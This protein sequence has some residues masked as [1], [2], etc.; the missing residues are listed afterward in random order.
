MIGVLF[1]LLVVDQLLLGAVGCLGQNA[2]HL[3]GHHAR[4]A[5]GGVVQRFIDRREAFHLQ[6]R[7][8]DLVDALEHAGQ[9]GNL[10]L[11]LDFILR[12]RGNRLLEAFH[13]RPHNRLRFF[14]VFQHLE[15]LRL[16]DLGLVELALQLRAL[17]LQLGI[18]RL[19]RH[20]DAAVELGNLL[21]QPSGF[22]PP[23]LILRL[24]VHQLARKLDISRL[25]LAI[26]LGVLGNRRVKRLDGA[27]RIGQDGLHRAVDILLANAIH[28]HLARP[29]FVEAPNQAFKP[30]RVFHGR[31]ITAQ[32]VELGGQ[33]LNQG[34]QIAGVLAAAADRC[35]ELAQ[36]GDVRGF[37]LAG[38]GKL[39]NR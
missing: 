15:V 22:Q 13:V 33:I 14:G 16:V 12:Q 37:L 28:H 20:L 34:L 32:V 2:L 6:R 21:L 38:R 7:L 4:G 23:L 1:H 39:V 5:V 8:H 36:I 30:A 31:D 9:V 3:L 29:L 10:F 35:V 18:G 25:Q 17:G 24:V 11:R 26:H 19:I 27:A